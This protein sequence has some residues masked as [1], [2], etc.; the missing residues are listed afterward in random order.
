MIQPN[1]HQV[2]YGFQY[3]VLTSPYQ[4][5]DYDAASD[6]QVVIHHVLTSSKNCDTPCGHLVFNQVYLNPYCLIWLFFYSK[7]FIFIFGL[8]KSR[9]LFK[10]MFYPQCKIMKFWNLSTFCENFIKM[11]LHPKN[12]N[13]F[14]FHKQKE[15]YTKTI[16]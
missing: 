3:H 2:S 1:A 13:I 6:Y 10:Y 9:E 7:L 15:T 12:K 4:Y 8:F 16:L 14:S 5:H 11:T